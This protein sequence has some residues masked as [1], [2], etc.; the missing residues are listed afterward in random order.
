MS[1]HGP[2][3]AGEMAGS[4]GMEGLERMQ[5]INLV[6]MTSQRMMSDAEVMPL[7]EAVV[8]GLTEE[9]APM[10]TVPGQ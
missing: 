7:A 8:A 6:G 2:S 5:R 9:L 10:N 3:P 4:V 1:G